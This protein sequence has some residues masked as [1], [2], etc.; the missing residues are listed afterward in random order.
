MKKAWENA[1]PGR[2]AKAMQSRLKYLSTHLIKLHPDKEEEEVKEGE[3][4]PDSEAEI[5]PP[6]TPL[7]MHEDKEEIL[8]LEPPPPPT[9]KEILPPLDITPFLRKASGEPRY[10]DED[11]IKRREEENKRQV[12]EYKA[13]RDQ[14]KNW[15]EQDKQMRNNI[16][17]K[18]LEQCEDLQEDLDDERDAFQLAREQYRQ[19]F[20]I[21]RKRSKISSAK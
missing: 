17:I 5:P 14:V 6:Q 3:E 11:E 10:L 19:K 12:E 21:Q 9:P 8:T 13:F 18:Q 1:E 16:K 7:S 20:I 2:A 4:K 15:R